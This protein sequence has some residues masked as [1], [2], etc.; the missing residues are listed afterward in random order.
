MQLFTV[1]SN[2]G[3]T[4]CGEK[5]YQKRI[6]DKP[7]PI[8][9]SGLGRLLMMLLLLLPRQPGKRSCVCNSFCG[10]RQPTGRGQ[11]PSSGVVRRWVPGRATSLESDPGPRAARRRDAAG[12]YPPGNSTLLLGSTSLRK[13][14]AWQWWHEHWSI[15]VTAVSSY[16]TADT[17]IVFC[18]N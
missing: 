15:G 16:K 10:C 12:P 11:Q 2:P 13:G 4:S 18:N 9:G 1:L 14:S 5:L 7:T 8:K 17:K 6:A 3:V